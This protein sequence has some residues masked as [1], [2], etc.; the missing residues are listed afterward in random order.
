MSSFSPNPRQELWKRLDLH[1]GHLAPGLSISFL[2][3]RTVEYYRGALKRQET[4]PAFHRTRRKQKSTEEGPS[5]SVVD[6]E[7]PSCTNNL[8]SSG[9]RKTSEHPDSSTLVDLDT[10]PA[11]VADPCTP[12]SKSTQQDT[13]IQ[14][15]EEGE[16]ASSEEMD[17]TESLPEGL[18]RCDSP[19]YR[20]PSLSPTLQLEQVRPEDQR[21]DTVT[22]PPRVDVSQLDNDPQLHLLPGYPLHCPPMVGDVNDFLTLCLEVCTLGTSYVQPQI[23]Q[24]AARLPGGRR[25]FV[26]VT[27]RESTMAVSL[28]KKMGYVFSREQQSYSPF[29]F[30]HENNDRVLELFTPKDAITELLQWL[31]SSLKRTDKSG[32]L[33]V[34][35]HRET[36]LLLLCFLD[37]ND[38]EGLLGIV[39]C[40]VALDTPLWE[41]LGLPKEKRRQLGFRNVASLLHFDNVPPH[42]SSLEKDIRWECEITELTLRSLRQHRTLADHCFA[43]TPTCMERVANFQSELV[44]FDKLCSHLQG[45][46]MEV[47][48][49][50]VKDICSLFPRAKACAPHYE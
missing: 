40:W 10:P 21:D 23:L 9:R 22:P 14:N 28:L 12:P 2:V 17:E 1:R 7:L 16:Y 26:P 39:R 33:L 20:P 4:S 38:R 15:Q 47:N 3:D 43:L 8:K 18:D 42:S 41:Q 45:M 32:V 30:V 37:H 31:K 6:V 36:L 34:S 48:G 27:P 49:E 5:V 13:Y 35:L 29:G 25:L 19:I 46:K 44:S 11:S 24:I 50:D